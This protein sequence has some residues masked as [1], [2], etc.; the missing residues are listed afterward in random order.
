[1]KNAIYRIIIGNKPSEQIELLQFDHNDTSLKLVAYNKGNGY[2]RVFTYG[3][4]I[5]WFALDR[6]TDCLNLSFDEYQEDTFLNNAI[7]EWQNK[8]K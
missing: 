5:E 1:M 6:E 7:Y 8:D 2:V 3:D 4:F